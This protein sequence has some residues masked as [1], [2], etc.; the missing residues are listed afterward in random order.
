M[1]R[2]ALRAFTVLF[3]F[4]TAESYGQICAHGRPTTESFYFFGLTTPTDQGGLGISTVT[5]YLS[6]AARNAT[7]LTTDTITNGAAGWTSCVGIFVPDFAVNTTAQRPPL[8]DFGT[9][10]SSLLINFIDAPAPTLNGTAEP[11]HWDPTDNSITLY[12]KCPLDGTYGMPCFGD[13]PGGAIRWDI[14]GFATTVI[15]HEIGHA[16]G[17]DHDSNDGSCAHGVMKSPLSPDDTNLGV[18]PAYCRLVNQINNMNA[19]CQKESPGD[20]EANPCESDAA[21]PRGGLG[22]PRGAGS[23]AGVDFCSEFSWLCDNGNPWS[24]SGIECNWGCVSYSDNFGGSGSSCSWGCFAAAVIAA[25]PKVASPAV[26][27]LAPFVALT[28]PTQ[29]AT[30]QGNITLSGFAMDFNGIASV[31]FGIDGQPVAV[32]NYRGGL[33]SPAACSLPLGIVH[34]ACRPN[35]GFSANL[36]TT[37]FANGSH[38]LSVVSYDT[39]GWTTS[40]EVP[41]VINN[42]PPCETVPPAVSI[43]APAN[44]STAGGTITITVNATDNVGVTKVELYVDNNLTATKTT[45]PFSFK[46]ST[47]SLSTGGHALKVR[48][49]DACGNATT[50][51]WSLCRCNRPVSRLLRRP[52]SPLPRAA[53][54]SAAR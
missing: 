14:P 30:V 15:A 38:T 50:P 26:E 45:E 54:L 18:T 46:L 40:V 6:D 33:S 28:S 7:F 12:G 32:T 21:S 9:L 20:G 41:I 29:S 1:S 53:R 43:T 47:T 24:G 16:L 3:V 13:H 49:Y 10:Q 23:G 48:A 5:I 51:P 36:D 52:R 11:A 8:S 22:G 39:T 42:P 2:L 44:G 19:P 31:S 17:M 4:L 35:S 27:G 34:S 25:T 37:P